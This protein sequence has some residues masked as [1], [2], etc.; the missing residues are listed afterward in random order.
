MNHHERCRTKYPVVLVHG[1]ALRDDMPLLDSWGRIPETLKAAG[2]SVHHGGQDSWNTHESSAA[3]LKSKLEEVL[4]M[5]GAEK[6]N[7]IAHSKGGLEARYLISNLG[8]ADKVASLTTVSSPHHGTRVADLMMGEIPDSLGLL[9]FN[10]FKF[11]AQ[12]L[13]F[14]ALDLL[15]RITG[16]QRPQA[17][18]AIGE[19]THAHMQTFN[20]SVVDAP[21]V[22]YQSYGTVMKRSLD[23]PF[24]ALTNGLLLREGE[25]E[26]D[27]LVSSSSCQWG[28]FRGLILPK[29]PS[30]GLSHGDM[31]DYR[32]TWVTGID[33]PDVYATMVEELKTMGF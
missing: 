24:F 5:T 11:L 14:R 2:A 3:E 23:D 6:L 17:R 7:L 21:G 32:G 22:Y 25:G 26:N 1:I 33:I 27:G 9:R 20:R 10:L 12:K 8:M 4:V 19:L 18:G 15:G 16:D 13:G 29:D 30:R 28:K 31:V